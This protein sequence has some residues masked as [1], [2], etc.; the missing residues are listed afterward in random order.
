MYF[1]N[2]RNCTLHLGLLKLSSFFSLALFSNGNRSGRQKNLTN[3][4]VQIKEFFKDVMYLFC[5]QGHLIFFLENYLFS[6][7]SE[8][9]AYSWVML[10]ASLWRIAYENWY[11]TRPLLLNESYF[12]NILCVICRIFDLKSLSD[13]DCIIS[14]SPNV[15]S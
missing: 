14:Y 4:Y 1:S 10:I 15:L 2:L 5:C 7:K 12:V 13:T 3:I 8:N 11:V 6:R 9:D